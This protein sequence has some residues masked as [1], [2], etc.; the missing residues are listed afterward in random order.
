MEFSKLFPNEWRKISD[1]RAHARTLYQKVL[2]ELFFDD[3]KVQTYFFILHCF[4]FVSSVVVVDPTTKKTWFHVLWWYVR[5]VCQK[6]LVVEWD[7]NR[8]IAYDLQKIYQ[9]S[10]KSNNRF[11]LSKMKKF[12]DTFYRSS[13]V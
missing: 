5:K 7:Q 13:K 10:E 1:E 2:F 8:T 11:S 4:A 3:T 12:H 6:H 9:F